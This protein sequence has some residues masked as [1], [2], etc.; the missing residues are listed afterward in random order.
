MRGRLIL[1]AAAAVA[2]LAPASA[3]AAVSSLGSDLSR[4][5]DVAVARQSDTAF[6]QIRRPSGVGDVAPDSGQITQ[7]EL[8]GCAIR[9]NNTDPYTFIHFQTLKPLGDGRVQVGVTSQG[10]DAVICGK[11]GADANTV[12][13]YHPEN[14]CIDRGSY[15]AYNNGG[16]FDAWNGAYTSGVRYQHFVRSGGS[17]LHMFTQ[18]DGTKNG[19]TFPGPS[20]AYNPSDDRP[21]QSSSADGLEVAMRGTLATGTHATGLCPGGTRE[22]DNAPKP[23][24]PPEWTAGRDPVSFQNDDAALNENGLLAVNLSCNL[25][26]R[27][28]DG[29]VSVVTSMAYKSSLKATAGAAATTKSKRAKARAKRKKKK[30]TAVQAAVAVGA[31]LG[32]RFFLIPSQ[33]TATVQIKLGPTALDLLRRHGRIRPAIVANVDGVPPSTSA[34]TI[35]AKGDLLRANKAL[36]AK[37][38]NKKR[39]KR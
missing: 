30:R 34:I 14:M 22:I 12:S 17:L 10:F 19:H 27:P 11:N 24:P 4:T 5:P 29:S 20:G 25:N 13:T 39:K 35:R 16:G 36:K 18:H 37:P 28:C 32:S 6:W 38:K 9:D 15:L 21:S 31:Q 3:G 8:K 26:F 7:V 23:P 1:A 33:T 2:L